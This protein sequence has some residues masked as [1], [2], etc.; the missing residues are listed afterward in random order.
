MFL[1]IPIMI[2]LFLSGLGVLPFKPIYCGK[3]SLK[4]C[5]VLLVQQFA[6]IGKQGIDVGEEI[7]RRCCSWVT[8]HHLPVENKPP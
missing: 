6:L 5:F 8:Y 3:P 4:F 7:L 1:I 2:I